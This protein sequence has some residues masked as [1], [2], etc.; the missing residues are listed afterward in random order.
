MERTINSG[1]VSR[2]RI[3]D[4]HHERSFGLRLSTISIHIF[5]GKFTAI[6]RSLHRNRREHIATAFLCDRPTSIRAF[7]GKNPPPFVQR[8]G[9]RAAIPSIRRQSS[10]G[11]HRVGSNHANRTA[12]RYG[13]LAESQ[14]YRHPLTASRLHFPLSWHL[15]NVVVWNPPNGCRCF[16]DSNDR[17]T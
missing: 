10:V 11:G 8:L 9:L 4:M 7:R 2:D 14:A 6:S 15:N 12:S 5:L 3:R 17:C 16:I 13:N 1:F